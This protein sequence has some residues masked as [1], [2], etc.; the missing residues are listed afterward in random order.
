MI[1]S[2]RDQLKTRSAGCWR[3]KAGEGYAHREP[4]TP[5]RNLT[6]RDVKSRASRVT[7]LLLSHIGDHGVAERRRTVQA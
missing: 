7:R 1:H 3:L 2:Q 5:D 6:V 4:D